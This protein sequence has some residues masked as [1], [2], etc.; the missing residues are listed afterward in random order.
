MQSLGNVSIFKKKE[1]KKVKILPTFATILL[2]IKPWDT[3][4]KSQDLNFKDFQLWPW[5]ELRKSSSQKSNFK[6]G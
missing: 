5:E 6:T 2:C 1:M 4:M 3:E